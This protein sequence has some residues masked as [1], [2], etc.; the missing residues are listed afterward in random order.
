MSYKFDKA[1]Q[2]RRLDKATTSMTSS[3]VIIFLY[4]AYLN[5]VSVAPITLSVVLVYLAVINVDYF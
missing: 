2:V 4:S 5:T 1:V 3:V